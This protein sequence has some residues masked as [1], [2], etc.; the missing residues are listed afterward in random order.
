M[1]PDPALAAAGD[2][3]MRVTY[4]PESVK[5]EMR[6]Q[7]KQEVLDTAKRDH[8][9]V[10]KLVPDWAMRIRLFG[11]IRVRAQE[12]IFPAGNDNT[13][14]FPNFNAINTGAPFDPSGTVFSPQLDV[15]R[16]RE[17]L[18]LRVARRAGGGSR[19]GLFRRLAH[20]QRA[21]TIC[22]PRPTS[23]SGWPTRGRAAI[24]AATPSGS[25]ARFLKYEL[26]GGDPNNNL[27]R[28]PRPFR[29]S[30]LLLDGDLG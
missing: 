23:R 16:N 8:W 12:D 3:A 19:A 9:A 6:E 14:S 13:G 1:A 10:P 28:Y 20:R 30:F 24:S 22:R 5:A 2:D 21:K 7:I 27:T 17:R 4:I 25:I 29:Q 26:G 15:D 18:R 11:D